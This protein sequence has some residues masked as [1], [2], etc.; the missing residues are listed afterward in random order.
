MTYYNRI[1]NA[2]R[3]A[4]VRGV[5][6]E[7]I[8]EIVMK[9]KTCEGCGEN[10]GDFIEGVCMECYDFINNYE[11]E[12]KGKEKENGEVE[13]VNGVTESLKEGYD[14]EELMD[15]AT[16]G[17][18]EA[19]LKEDEWG[20]I[21]YCRKCME[22][23]VDATRYIGEVKGYGKCERCYE[24]RDMYEWNQ[25]AGHHCQ[26]KGED[27]ESVWTKDGICDHHYH[28]VCEDCW[29]RMYKREIKQSEYY[30]RVRQEQVLE[31]DRRIVKEMRVEEETREEMGL[32][33]EQ[34]KSRQIRENTSDLYKNWPEKRTWMEEHMYWANAERYHNFCEVCST[35][36]RPRFIKRENAEFVALK[37][38]LYLISCKG[39][40]EN[41][42]DRWPEIYSSDNVDYDLDDGTTEDSEPVK[43]QENDQWENRSEVKGSWEEQ[44]NEQM[45]EGWG[46]PSNWESSSTWTEVVAV[47]RNPP[48]EKDRVVTQIVQRE[49][50]LPQ[51]RFTREQGPP[52]REFR[53]NVQN[54][55]TDKEVIDMAQRMTMKKFGDI[56]DQLMK[57]APRIICKER[58]KR[59]CSCRDDVQLY[60]FMAQMV[61]KE[62]YIK[63]AH[64]FYNQ[65][66]EEEGRNNERST[67][68]MFP[69]I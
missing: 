60:Q 14:P 56:R 7:T 19:P 23:Q 46:E 24:K 15:I 18:C 5:S 26:V 48:R 3:E 8:K 58:V 34:V 50:Q 35:K 28:S 40:L 13:W 57:R 61:C 37:R 16:C 27:C 12:P 17:S 11:K 55:R 36:E 21:T 38:G 59:K 68:D 9:K 29:R 22:A 51:R 30:E 39:C 65:F 31:K 25:V 52:R 44:V 63:K 49:Q 67:T 64:Y 2:V 1:Q 10:K 43:V 32:Y 66:L 41:I 69:K 42:H 62:A 54:R 33:Y 47:N 45:N 20:K 4:M 6:K 53:N